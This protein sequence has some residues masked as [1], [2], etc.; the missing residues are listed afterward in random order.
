MNAPAQFVSSRKEGAVGIVVI[1]RTERRNAL[2]LQVKPQVTNDGSVVLQLNLDRS[3]PNFSVNPPTISRRSI[4]TSLLVKDG[5][6]A[7]IG[8]I[9]TRNVGQAYSKIPWL[10]EIP[11]LGWL[12]KNRSDT[13]ARSELL[14]FISPRI[15][16]RGTSLPP[17][18]GA[19][20]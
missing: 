19:I 9:Y 4:R 1:D 5:E 14:I 8:G 10:A 6:T 17:P 16:N 2:N 12:F 7:V 18:A 20:Q 15:V 13:D 3:E 11:V